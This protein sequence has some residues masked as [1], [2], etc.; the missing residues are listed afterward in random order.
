MS[1]TVKAFLK[2]EG[3]WDGEIRRFQIPADVSSSF[4]FLARKLCEIFPSLRPGNFSLYWTDGEGDHVSFSTDEELLEALG[5]VSDSVFKV[6]IDRK[7]GPVHENEQMGQDRD[8]PVHRGVVCDGCQIGPIVGPRYKCMTCPDYDLC[9][10]CEGAGLHVEHDMIKITEP[11]SFPGFPEF[12]CGGPMGP[13]GPGPNGGFAPP[14]YFRRWM[15][16]FMKRWH[17][18]HAPG[19]EGGATDQDEKADEKMEDTPEGQKQDSEES[20]GEEF[21]RNIG[22]SVA[23][24]LDPFGIDVDVEVAK[25]EPQGEKNAEEGEDGSPCRGKKGKRGAGGRCGGGRGGGRGG[26]GKRGPPHGGPGPWGMWGWGTMPGGPGGCPFGPGGPEM[27]PG[28]GK[29]RHCNKKQDKPAEATTTQAAPNTHQTPPA[30]EKPVNLMD[31][32]VDSE[33]TPAPQRPK[34]PVRMDGENGTH[35]HDDQTWTILNP[36]NGQPKPQREQPPQSGSQ[37]APSAPPTGPQESIYPPADP[38]I[39]E[40][41]IQMTNMGFSNEGGWLTRLLE[42]KNGDIIQV[43]D[44]IRPQQRP[45]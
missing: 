18:R 33:K 30:S 12:P 31:F 23:K 43:L 11:A 39:A 19:F 20:S 25:D 13:M 15:Q 9:R 27:R 36:E 5:F 35:Q 42:A 45:R 17:N 34:S 8:A 21:L 3:K 28:C 32:V 44:A 14:P 2:N 41:L 1:L 7:D 38:K 29:P 24:M 40:A 6:Y 22:E 37:G 26:C 16:R 4:D 10:G